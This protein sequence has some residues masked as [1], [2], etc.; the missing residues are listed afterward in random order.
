MIPTLALAAICAIMTWDLEITK[1]EASER[2]SLISYDVVVDEYISNPS[3]VL[4]FLLDSRFRGAVPC[5]QRYV[6]CSFYVNSS[7]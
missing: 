3:P 1:F 6:R 5:P 4:G 2:G 7:E